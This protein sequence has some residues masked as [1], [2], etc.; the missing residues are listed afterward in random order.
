MIELSITFKDS[1][2]TL[3]K[4]SLNYNSF[5]LAKDNEELLKMVEDVALEFKGEVETES[6]DITVKAKMTWYFL[7][8]I[9]P[10]PP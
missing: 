1:E 8:L 5:L 6:P 2:R 10:P 7:S 4:K 3:T 9:H